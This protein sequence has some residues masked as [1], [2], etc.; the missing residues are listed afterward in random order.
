MTTRQR[1]LN[2]CDQQTE[3]VSR[4]LRD[5]DASDA[6]IKDITGMIREPYM[7]LIEIYEALERMKRIYRECL[8]PY[9]TEE[10]E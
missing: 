8:P 2:E 5:T 3:T 9:I 10:D 7:E 4:W 6:L 1:M